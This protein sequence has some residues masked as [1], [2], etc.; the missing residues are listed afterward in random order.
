MANR[1]LQIVRISCIVSLSITLIPLLLL[2]LREVWIHRDWIVIFPFILLS[3]LWLLY[4][5]AL[6]NLR[7]SQSLD[8]ESFKRGL[9]TAVSWGSIVLI[10]S[11]L[12]L[13][14]NSEEC[15]P[16]K[17][18]AFFSLV[19]AATQ[20]A[21]LAGS[22]K[23]YLS[24]E[25]QTDDWHILT[26]R[27]W[28]SLIGLPLLVLPWMLAPRIESPEL[29]AVGTLRTIARA[30]RDYAT[31]HPRQGFAPSLKAL[32]PAPGA[33]LVDPVIASG[34]K[35]GYVFSLQQGIPEE[36]GR[37][38][39]YSLLAA[40]VKRPN[41]GTHSF[42]TDETGTLRYTKENRTASADDPPLE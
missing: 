7:P 8:P 23:A 16:D 22:V 2:D 19:V 25:R 41:C 27:V 28:I 39:K 34:V 21:L 14:K 26:V 42:F 24:M 31:A 6:W 18:V 38:L 3:P 9:A 13:W 20:I 17:Y 4:A 36:D 5:L 37:I 33:G 30:Q 15:A 35:N 11:S 40:P 29:S 1:W 10:F 32:G 12:V